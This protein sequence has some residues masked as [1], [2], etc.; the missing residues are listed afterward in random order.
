MADLQSDAWSLKASASV[1]LTRSVAH[2]ELKLPILSRVPDPSLAALADSNP[3][4]ASRWRRTRPGIASTLIRKAQSEG[5]GTGT[6][7]SKMFVLPCV[8]THCAVSCG[9]PRLFASP[10]PRLPTR[11]GAIRTF[12]SAASC[13]LVRVPPP[14]SQ[15]VSGRFRRE[16]VKA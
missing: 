3:S 5:E 10:D 7:D 15:M 1:E 12:P 11:P 16:W 4:D 14:A 13:A 9:T 6:G 2:R 8:S